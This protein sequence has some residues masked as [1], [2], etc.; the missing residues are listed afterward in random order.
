MRK[1]GIDSI[2]ISVCYISILGFLSLTVHRLHEG[3]VDTIVGYATH[4]ACAA[5]LQHLT[6]PFERSGAR[7]VPQ[8]R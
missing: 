1:S 2:P 7:C 6:P 8:H 4:S 5:I 3:R